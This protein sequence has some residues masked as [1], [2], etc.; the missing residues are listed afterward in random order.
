MGSAAA[1]PPAHQANF[2]RSAASSYE[3]DVRPPPRDGS[4]GGGRASYQHQQPRTT[5]LDPEEMYVRQERIGKGSFG[6][7]YKG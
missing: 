2:H 1:T 6:E 7:V 3:S 4:A 5:T